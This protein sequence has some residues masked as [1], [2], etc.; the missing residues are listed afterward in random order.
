MPIR[1]TKFSRIGF[2]LLEAI[3]AFVLL[4][5]V[6]LHVL[7]YDLKPLATVCIPVLAVFFGFTS[8]LYNRA[9][10][11]AKGKSQN[12]TLYAAERAMQGTLFFFFGTVLGAILAG[13]LAYFGFSLAPP[14]PTLKNLWLILFIGPYALLQIGYQS[15]M[16]AIWSISPE[17]LGHISA[18]QLRRRVQQ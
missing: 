14:N 2:R 6:W 17:F 16:H 12:R 10:A 15:F 1:R 8:V 4:V 13:L 5:V 3:G 9:R 7:S 11:L 18:R